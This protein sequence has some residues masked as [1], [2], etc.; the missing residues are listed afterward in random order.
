MPAMHLG[1]K[2]PDPTK[3]DLGGVWR[4][5]SRYSKEARIESL[6]AS[7]RVLSRTVAVVAQILD[8]AEEIKKD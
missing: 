3:T 2:P 6:E 1:L 7:G 5:I 4:Y 8:T